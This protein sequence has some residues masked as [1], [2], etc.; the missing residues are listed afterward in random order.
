MLRLRRDPWS[1]WQT[2]VC[3]KLLWKYLVYLVMWVYLSE[4][5]LTL[6]QLN[7][8]DVLGIKKLWRSTSLTLLQQF[9]CNT[10]VTETDAIR[11][12]K[13]RSEQPA[14]YCMFRML[15]SVIATD[16]NR[17]VCIRQTRNDEEVTDWWKWWAIIFL[18]KKQEK[19][20][21]QSTSSKKKREKE[22]ERQAPAGWEHLDSSLAASP[23]PLFS[24]S[25]PPRCG[26]KKCDE[27]EREKEER[28]GRND[29]GLDG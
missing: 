8:Q 7:K 6:Q 23:Y 17:V 26:K 15:T 11:D 18:Y 12:V 4:K 21:L 22:K 2:L 9:N 25:L 16:Y 3:V 14:F 19:K 13:K 20:K 27:R 29:S 1:R 24:P 10:Q 5:L 28:G